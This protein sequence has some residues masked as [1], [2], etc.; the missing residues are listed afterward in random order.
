[1]LYIGKFDPQKPYNAVYYDGTSKNYYVK[2]FLVELKT[3]RNK[4]PIV[5]EHKDS[6]LAIFS[7]AKEA[8][9]KFHFLKGKEKEKLETE[10]NLSEMI[11]VKGWKALG[12]RLSQ[13]LVTGKLEEVV[14][15]VEPEV[16]E[17]VKPTATIEWDIQPS[18]IAKKKGQ[19]GD[20]F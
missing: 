1:M 18:E 11:D 3:E 2:R 8:F 20:L 15:V 13:H 12:N 9:V 19:Q 14:K 4:V 16:V 6:K 7:D 17:E 10:V 5:T